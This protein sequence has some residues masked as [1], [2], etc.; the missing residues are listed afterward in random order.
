VTKSFHSWI[1]WLFASIFILAAAGFA[2]TQE[3]WIILLPVFFLAALL[4]VQHP[5]MLF[6]LLLMSIP[7]SVEYNFNP[8]LGTDLPDE[9]LML[10][11][12]LSIFIWFL[13]RGKVNGRL[14][15]VLLLIVL[16]LIWSGVSVI[17]S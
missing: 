3:I 14:H 10:L 6:Y 12:S 13:Y 11:M 17:T 9:P 5:E 4:L 7:W 16:Q 8:H 15:P 1:T 2:Y